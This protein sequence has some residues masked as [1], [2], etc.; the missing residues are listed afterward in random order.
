M[1]KEFKEA[2]DDLIDAY[3]EGTRDNSQYRQQTEA[4]IISALEL[5]LMAL[6]KN[7]EQE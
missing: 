2:L 1:R 4:E 6:N 3:M 5:K 7:Q